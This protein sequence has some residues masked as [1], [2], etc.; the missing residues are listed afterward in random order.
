MT[1]TTIVV[2]LFAAA[3]L[4]LLDK[5]LLASAKARLRAGADPRH[6]IGRRRA[7]DERRIAAQRTMARYPWGPPGGGPWGPQGGGSW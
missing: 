7:E 2:I 5:M 3:A 1:A 6:A 4:V